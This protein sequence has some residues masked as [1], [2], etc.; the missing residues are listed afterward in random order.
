VV[1][2]LDGD[3]ER[4]GGLGGSVWAVAITGRLRSAKRVRSKQDINDDHKPPVLAYANRIKGLG[5]D[6][7]DRAGRGTGI[8]G[9]WTTN[10]RAI[11]VKE[12]RRR[13]KWPLVS[14]TWAAGVLHLH[15]QR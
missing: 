3:V 6:M 7:K 15:P 8:S 13:G 12:M 4:T 1:Q 5:H 2:P 14:L 11:R 9:P 10:L